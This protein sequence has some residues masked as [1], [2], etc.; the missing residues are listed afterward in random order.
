MAQQ[1][2]DGILIHRNADMETMNVNCPEENL[3]KRCGFK[4]ADGFKVQTSWKTPRGTSIFLYA[5]AVGKANTENQCEFP[6][7]VESTLFFGK[8]LLVHKLENG[9]LTELTLDEW[10]KFADVLIGGTESIASESEDERSVDEV[11]PDATYTQEGYLMDGFVVADD[12]LEEEP[13]E[14]HSNAMKE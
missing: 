9:A 13:Y 11:D 1:R 7:P 5:K 14:T 10:N 6:P 8:C 12:E 4:T 3:F 2:I